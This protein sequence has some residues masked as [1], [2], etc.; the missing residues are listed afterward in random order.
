[1]SDSVKKFGQH[2]RYYRR[3]KKLSQEQLAELCGLH[4]TYIGQLERGEKNASIETV[5]QLC[6]GLGITPAIL[7]ENISADADSTPAQEAYELFLSV[8]A[9]KQQTLLELLRNAVRLME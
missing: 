3:E 8:P 5:I 6:R 1:M 7:F 4:P 2:V 9:D